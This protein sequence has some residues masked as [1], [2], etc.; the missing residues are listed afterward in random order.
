MSE[1][2]G[3]ERPR[4]LLRRELR[5]P[6][7]EPHLAWSVLGLALLVLF[8]L[9][10][11][12]FQGRVFYVRDIHLQWY[13]QVQSFVRSIASGSWPLW[14]PYVS[15]GQPLLANANNQVLYPLTWLNLLVRPWT[16]YTL[17][18]G[19]HLLF[20]GC[21]VLALGRR[22]GIS[23]AGS[24][25][26]AAIWITSGPF[27][28][29]G[30]VWNHLAAAAW[31]PWVILAADRAWSSGRPTHAL[32]WGA[33]MAAQI[34]AGS[35]DFFVL[36][37][38]VLLVHGLW[39]GR[40]R[41]ARSTPRRLAFT[42]AI[43]FSFAVA[44]SAAQ[45]LPSLELANRSE[46]WRQAERTRTY[47]SVHPVAMLQTLVPVSWDAL[48]LQRRYRASLFEEREPY[49]LSLYLGLPVVALAL[50][51]WAGPARS[52]RA[53]LAATAIGALLIALGK[54]GF[55][56]GAA[57]WLL[58]PLKVLR[59]PAKAM[60]FAAFAVSLL[61]GLGFDVWA[62]PS[63]DESRRHWRAFLLGPLIAATGAAG[64]SAVFLHR[65]A[66]ALG[67]LFLDRGAA[68]A[69]F[70]SLLVPVVSRLGVLAVIGVLLLAFAALRS[71]R[72]GW[73]G[74]TAALVA[75]LAVADL[76]VAHAKL[77]PTAPKAL[78]TARP[79]VLEAIHQQD[80]N[81][82]HVYDYLAAP[83]LSERHLGRAVPYPGE[84]SDSPLLW[85]AALAMRLCLL[86]P[87]AGA[88]G[89]Y[90]SF[91]RDVLGIQPR[92]LA[93]LNAL[94]VAAE[95]TPAYPRLLRIG[96][97]G[98]VVALHADGFD[99]LVPAAARAGPYAEPLQVLNVPGHV[100]RTYLVGRGRVAEGEAGIQA[101]LD[102]SF[103]PVTEVVLEKGPTRRAGSAF[104]G[105]SR[106]VELD[107]DH[108]RLETDASEA[109]YAV[110]V[111]SYDPGW[112]AAV[113]GRSA[114]V[115]RANVAFRAVE[116][117]AGRHTVDL[118][119]RPRAFATGLAISVAALLGAGAAA[120]R[121]RP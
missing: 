32:L 62:R 79:D 15:F 101:L 4:G 5:L 71:R 106:I 64:L 52:A 60:V 96:A 35:P 68:E 77:N 89:I 37:A 20:S 109:G 43:A 53:P 84:R 100:P 26:A 112:R 1:A 76:A 19:L 40:G 88:W 115:L 11:P 72:A 63:P 54:N 67:P 22:F 16:Y 82:L 121:S 102:P 83:G 93:E 48:P 117:P 30:N 78:F 99:D 59:F 7:V 119:Y 45:V 87:T 97:V 42:A 95:G 114:P 10:E 8:F 73:A 66:E 85:R 56:Y 38:L 91:S 44:L 13:G 103:D 55:V 94:L 31:M 17:F 90:D 98:Q 2:R 116:V 80:R 104:A 49:L 74:A 46:R 36:T 33:A 14:D 41:G 25:V 107:P 23:P 65:M 9:R 86:P 24:F 39:T 28:S 50:A 57:V 70:S 34:L 51:A 3:P 12:V 108:V 69:S 92:P 61:A 6:D 18:L 21:G 75:I 110:L 113:D 111:D 58:P 47:W 120:A 118:T 105:T 29:L 81:R 27:L